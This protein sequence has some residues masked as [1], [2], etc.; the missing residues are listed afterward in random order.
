[1]A[2]AEILIINLWFQDIGRWDAANY[3]LLKTVFELNL[4][5]FGQHRYDT[6]FSGSTC[7]HAR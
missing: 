4:Q 6:T 2:L 3:G 5:L 1:L 7:V